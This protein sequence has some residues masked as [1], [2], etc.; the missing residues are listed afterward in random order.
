MCISLMPPQEM[1]CPKNHSVPSTS[2]LLVTGT[3]TVV[4]TPP[5]MNMMGTALAQVIPVKSA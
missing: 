3:S 5:P 1:I 2:I 4:P